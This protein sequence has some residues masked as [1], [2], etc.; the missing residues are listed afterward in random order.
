MTAFGLM[1]KYYSL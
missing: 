1:N